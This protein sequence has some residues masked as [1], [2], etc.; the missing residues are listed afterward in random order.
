MTG[1]IRR[2]YDVP[3]VNALLNAPDIRPTIGGEG[4]LDATALLTDHRN[5]CLVG[6]AGGMLFAWRGP[7]I[8][9]VHCFFRVRGREAIAAAVDMVAMMGRALLWAL[10]PEARRDVRWFA[11]KVGFR[12]HGM[13]DTPD[14]GRCE[15]FVKGEV[16]C[17]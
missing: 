14:L 2:T 7:S 17:R 6:D 3:A 13:M 8:F 9:E 1:A 16:S 10:A 11:R 15:L 4:E 5:V 12:S